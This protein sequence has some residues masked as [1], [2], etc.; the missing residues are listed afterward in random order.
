MMRYWNVEQENL[1]KQY[2]QLGKILFENSKNKNKFL[3]SNKWDL[4]TKEG[5]WK[6]PISKQY[7]GMDLSWQEAAIAING[8]M[9]ISQDYEFI[10]FIIEQ[11]TTIYFVSKYTNL[12]HKKL[13]LA[14]LI[15]GEI[16]NESI[17]E[18]INK[19][20]ISRQDMTRFK[21][22]LYESSAIEFVFS[23]IKKYGH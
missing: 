16:I 19:N 6:L 11:F 14:R 1:Y 12:I 7:G 9:S 17:I 21:K 2:A 23:L 10:P 15:K 13:Y 20:I 4:I 8:L 5:I 3:F 18:D 22:F